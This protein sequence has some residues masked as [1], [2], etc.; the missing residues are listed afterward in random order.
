MSWPSAYACAP[1]LGGRHGAYAMRPIGWADREPIRRW[2][3]E[4]IDVLRQRAPLTPA[5]QDA[6][7]RGVVGPQLDQL[8]P[9][10]VLVAVDLAGT[11][12]GYG[13]VVHLAWGDRR[14]EISFLTDT[15]RLADATFAADWRAYLAMIV[16][17]A[18]DQLR[19]HKLTTETYAFRTGLIPLLEEAGFERE[20]VLREHNDVDGVWVDSLAHGLLL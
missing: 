5:D 20:G 8:E 2:R 3:N 15:D 4:Q 12:V 10:Q 19:L 11:L 7:Y 1:T 14:G 6:Y 13:G 18:R 9:P 16:P 17:A